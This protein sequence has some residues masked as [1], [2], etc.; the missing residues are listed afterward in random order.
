MP[1]RQRPPAAEA[2]ASLRQQIL[3]LL[4]S[5][6]YQP[7]MPPALSAALKLGDDQQETFTEVLR[8]LQDEGLVVDLRHKGLAL[9]SSADL[10]MGRITFT[11]S[12]AAF[13]ASADGERE[14]FVP[15]GNSGTAF[16]GDRVLV[17]LGAR[18]AGPR[19]RASE[20]PEGTVIRV[21]DRRSLTFVG[22]LKQMRRL[23]HVKPMRSS[24]QRDVLVP[25]AGG[26]QVGDRV[27]VR[28][29][30][31]RELERDMQLTGRCNE[32]CD[33]PP[34]ATAAAPVMAPA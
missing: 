9:A 5:A 22:T 1:K 8:E 11:R 21:I 23:Y 25:D 19:A 33:D 2:G 14:C 30:G 4:E 28:L 32:V 15:P 16:P 24:F 26:A 31:A 17:R 18:R 6:D 34:K 7:L 12:G 20:L 3:D 27:L 10:L 13:V 29:P